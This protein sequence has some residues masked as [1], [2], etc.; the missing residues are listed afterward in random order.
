MKL[1]EEQKQ[2]IKEEWGD[3]EG[4]HGLWDDFMADRLH[5]LDPEFMADLKKAFEGAT[6]WY[7]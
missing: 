3:W 6:F 2:K 7:A 5:D 4:V 1:T